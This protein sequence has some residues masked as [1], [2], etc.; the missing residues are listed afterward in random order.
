MF[1]R[2]F[3]LFA[4]I[5]IIELYLLIKVGGM[6]GALNT[7]VIILF[8]ATAGAYLA[9]SQG[10]A[11][12]KKINDAV[13]EGRPPAAELMDGLFVLIGGFM[14]LTPGFLTDF[15]GLSMLIPPVRT[16]Y[17]KIAAKI[18]K[19]KINTGEWNFRLFG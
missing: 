17:K 14:L 12:L 11:V 19:H 1:I 5:P 3:I 15:L 7:V 8:T 9:K 2:L 13:S 18:F 6:I 10:F 16:I 4:L